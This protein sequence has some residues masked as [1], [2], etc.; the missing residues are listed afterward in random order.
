MKENNNLYFINFS[1]I[2]FSKLNLLW[3]STLVSFTGEEISSLHVFV[4]V[5]TIITH[6]SVLY[7]P[8]ALLSILK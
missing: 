4:L 8:N 3:T 6:L 2:C 5:I 7:D 1:L